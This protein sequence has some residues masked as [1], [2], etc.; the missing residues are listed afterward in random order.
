MIEISKII[1]TYPKEIKDVL[2]KLACG[3]VED[4]I[5]NISTMNT[6]EFDSQD[7]ENLKLLFNYYIRTYDYLMQLYN[8][9]Y[10]SEIKWG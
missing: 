4:K 1:K 10:K 8:E 5:N 7:E 3:Y 9:N 6:L 2:K